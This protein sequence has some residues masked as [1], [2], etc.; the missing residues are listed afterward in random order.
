MVVLTDVCTVT[1]AVR[2]EFLLYKLHG[3]VVGF[4]C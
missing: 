4:Q 2:T 3:G 1:E